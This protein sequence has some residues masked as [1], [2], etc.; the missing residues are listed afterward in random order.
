MDTLQFQEFYGDC[1]KGFAKSTI[2][3]L[4]EEFNR[5]VGCSGWCF[6]RGVSNR[7]LIEELLA[8]GIDCSCIYDGKSLSFKHKV[9]R[10]RNK[11]FIDYSECKND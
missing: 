6:A 8:R 2:K 4:I 5:Q 3:A 9:F 11:L 1:K 10:E 7:A